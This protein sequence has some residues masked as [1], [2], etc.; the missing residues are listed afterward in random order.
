[1]ALQIEKFESA[2]TLTSAFATKLVELLEAGIA[3]NGRASLVVSG[4][5]TPLALFKTL[6][7]T[8][9]AWDKV[10]ITLADE[11]WVDGDHDASNTKLVKEN[12]IL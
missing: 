6:S 4:G 9:L 5:R 1:M 3:N 2:D 11:R 10:D 8:E 12:S 7:N